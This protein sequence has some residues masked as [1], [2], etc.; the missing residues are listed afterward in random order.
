MAIK[1]SRDKK[2][3]KKNKRKEGGKVAVTLPET[4]QC[5]GKQEEEKKKSLST[6]SRTRGH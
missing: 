3:E 6:S 2:E 4:G 5:N 1:E